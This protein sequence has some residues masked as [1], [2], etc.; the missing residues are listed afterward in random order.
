MSHRELTS[1]SA[2]LLQRKYAY[3]FVSESQDTLLIPTFRTRSVVQEFT[4]AQTHIAFFDNSGISF[5]LPSFV[6]LSTDTHSSYVTVVASWGSAGHTRTRQLFQAHALTLPVSPQAE[7]IQRPRLLSHLAMGALAVGMGSMLALAGWAVHNKPPIYAPHTLA[8]LPDQFED[9]FTFTVDPA[10]A[11]L[12]ASDVGRHRIMELD[13][14]GQPERTVLTGET[15]CF[16]NQ[17]TV[18]ENQLYVVNTNHHKLQWF[19]LDE[20]PQFAGEW[21]IVDAAPAQIEC[22]DPDKE[23]IRRFFGI[24]LRQTNG[25]A[26]AHDVATPGRV[27]PIAAQRDVHGAWWVLNASSG[28][29]HADVLVLM[30]KVTIQR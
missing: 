7:Q 12:F 22:I 11:R 5:G 15:L 16:P 24:T 29:T 8:E 25:C 28:L 26:H 19:T 18:W 30:R 4:P 10:G 23:R 2:A 6:R 27:W 21:L 14:N 20:H 9:V 1:G 3:L 17:V 13:C